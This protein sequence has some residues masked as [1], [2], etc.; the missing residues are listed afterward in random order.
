M[1]ASFGR[2][3]TQRNGD[4]SVRVQNDISLE[5]SLHLLRRL[6]DSTSTI[7]QPLAFT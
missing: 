5:P 4:L 3:D 2:A 6:V 1:Y 7:A